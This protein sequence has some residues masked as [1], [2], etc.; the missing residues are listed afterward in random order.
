MLWSAAKEWLKGRW[1]RKHFDAAFVSGARAAF[2]VETLGIPRHRVWRGY[3]VVENTHF[4]AGADSVRQ[5]APDHRRALNLPE[6]YF[7]FV[8]R[9]AEEKNLVRLLD[10]YA[11]YRA[12]AGDEAWRLVMVGSGPQEEELTERVASMD[13]AG[14]HWLG[15]KMVDELPAYYALA[16]AFVLRSRAEISGSKVRVTCRRR[17]AASLVC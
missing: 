7:L 10:A 8:G 12:R 6:R 17:R 11:A 15:A 9:F 16:S 14:V 3:D 4:A 2:Y 1:V 5:E 13:M